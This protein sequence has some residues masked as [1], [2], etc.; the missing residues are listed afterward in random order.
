[1]TPRSDWEQGCSSGHSMLDS[2]SRCR[3][4]ITSATRRSIPLRSRPRRR[5]WQRL[6]SG[7]WRS[8]GVA[9]GTTNEDSGLPCCP[10]ACGTAN[11]PMV[12]R[13][14]QTRRQAETRWSPA[15]GIVGSPF[16]P[17]TIHPATREIQRFVGAARRGYGPR[18]E[19]PVQVER[20][21]VRLPRRPELRSPPDAAAPGR[22][23]R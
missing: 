18:T 2:R 14:T 21:R 22:G 16:A 15:R 1:M 9:G 3:S 12:A 5:T 6:Q 11:A 7:A 8:P 10:G 23:G 19:C 20:H 13:T 4:R 17:G